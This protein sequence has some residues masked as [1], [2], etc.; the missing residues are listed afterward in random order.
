MKDTT[1]DTKDIIPMY[2]LLLSI[3]KY[4]D[5]SNVTIEDITAGVI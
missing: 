2:A 5:I 3:A 1:M 4:R